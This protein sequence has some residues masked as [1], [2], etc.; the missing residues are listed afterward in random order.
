MLRFS[1]ARR[2][3]FFWGLATLFPVGLNYAAFLLLGAAMA[4]DRPQWAERRQRLR[5]APHRW[6]AWLFLGWCALILAFGPH[7]P[8]TPSNA[9]HALRIVL[10]VWLALALARDEAIAALHGFGLGLLASLA[11]VLAGRTIG[12]PQFVLWDSLL[13]YQGNKSVADALLMA[14][15]VTTL[16]LCLP[17]LEG[18]R[19]VAAG[20]LMLALLALLAWVLPSRTA[21]LIILAAGG[22]GLLHQIGRAHV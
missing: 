19:R 8:E 21:W 14:L 1:L 2:A 7:Y 17:F 9:W 5:A 3:A 18:R 13:L 6:L 10:V 20:T 15:A 11:I 22:A 16:T 4:A 12:L